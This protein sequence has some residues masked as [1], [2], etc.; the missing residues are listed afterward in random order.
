MVRRMGTQQAGEGG[1]RGHTV[2]SI[3][4]VLGRTQ[5]ELA[6]ALGISP[7]AIQSYEQ[8]WRQPPM[9]VMIQLLVLLA[10]Q[11]RHSGEDKPCWEVRN[12]PLPTRSSC[13]AFTVGRGQFCWFI[14]AKRC[15]P[16]RDES[17][18]GTLACME[19]PVILRL[20]K[21]SGRSA[22]VRTPKE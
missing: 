20:L 8:G 21:G 1:R 9:R 16:R 11:R 10:I 18:T 17:A 13:P 12:C 19:C 15:P 3:R 6:L 7:K 14:G 22:P 4:C 2:K 5:A